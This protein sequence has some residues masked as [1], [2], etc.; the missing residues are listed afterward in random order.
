MGPWACGLWFDFEVMSPRVLG[1]EF[2]LASVI[3]PGPV[4][5]GSP[6]PPSRV[7]ARA[8]ARAGGRARR[9][10]RAAARAARSA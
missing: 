3:K 8:R 2:L 9:R 10:R 6:L 7:R 5:L 1:E 4:C